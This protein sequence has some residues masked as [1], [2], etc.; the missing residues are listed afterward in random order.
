M[1]IINHFNPNGTEHEDWFK[2][3]YLQSLG[4]LNKQ[5][6]ND[7]F[8]GIICANNKEIAIFE[9]KLVTLP[10]IQREIDKQLK[11]YE[12]SEY[13]HAL[14]KQKEIRSQL[15]DIIAKASKQVLSK[16]P[17]DRLSRI[18]YL[19]QNSPD[20]NKGD[21]IDAIKSNRQIVLNEDGTVFS[22]YGCEQS[23]NKEVLDLFHNKDLS[24]LICLILDSEP[25]GYIVKIIQNK[26][27]NIL[28]PNIFCSGYNTE[29]L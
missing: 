6:T 8:E 19:I 17:K 25:P 21:I 4:L 7:D 15:Q 1:K 26:N 11:Q 10:N 9:L 12:D 14:P 20:F 13:L 29:I 16:K 27:A 22:T 2:D 24:G 23:D 3:Y 18:I 28:I 5:I